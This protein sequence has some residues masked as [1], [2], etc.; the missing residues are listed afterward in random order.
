MTFSAEPEQPAY[1]R[2]GKGGWQ[3]VLNADRIVQDTVRGKQTQHGIIARTALGATL[4]P[5]GLGGQ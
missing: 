1:F 5:A 3:K 2:S 4:P